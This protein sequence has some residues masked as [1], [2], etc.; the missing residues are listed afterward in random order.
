MSFWGLVM[1]P[2][3]ACVLAAASQGVPQLASQQPGGTS[4]PKEATQQ[5]DKVSG[6]ILVLKVDPKYTTRA[7]KAGIEGTVVL[8]I[9]VEPDGK[10][11]NIL[12]L[13]SLDSDLDQEAILAVSQWRFKP[14]MKDGKPVTVA[15]T[16]EVNFRLLQSDEY[17]AAASER[18]PKAGVKTPPR[19]SES[20]TT[21]A[22]LS[23]V[24]QPRLA[25]IIEPKYPA[26][27]LGS[28]LEGKVLIRIIVDTTGVP[29]SPEIVESSDPRLNEAAKTA[30]REWRY[31]PGKLNGE[32]T[33]LP[34]LAE[35]YFEKPKG[36]SS[37]PGSDRQTTARSS[38]EKT[39]AL[40]EHHKPTPQPPRE[41]KEVDFFGTAQTSLGNTSNRLRLR[42]ENFQLISDWR[43]QN[44]LSQLLLALE[45]ARALFLH[46]YGKVPEGVVTVIVNQNLEETRSSC[47]T[48][49]GAG[50]Y[51]NRAGAHSIILSKDAF[52]N[53]A[54][55]PA[56]HEYTHLAQ[57]LMGYDWA[58]PWV[59]EGIAGY[60]EN[61]E[62]KQGKL[63][64][65]YFDPRRPVPSWF[66]LETIM[67]IDY[68]TMKEHMNSQ[69]AQAFYAESHL[70]IHMLRHTPKYNE[71]LSEFLGA[72]KKGQDS[73]TAVREFYGVSTS[74]LNDELVEYYRRGKYKKMEVYEGVRVPNSITVDGSG[75]KV[76]V[77]EKKCTWCSVRKVLRHVPI[78]IPI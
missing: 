73:K 54:A 69:N 29:Q 20:K 4:P 23:G 22:P 14:G 16:V 6:P 32:P 10:P 31:L 58:P 47:Q 68:N 62:F 13:R 57:N 61:I 70:L 1:A 37:T 26:E 63:Y 48:T 51:S 65:G 44:Q 35:I 18:V 36:T 39:G 25:H 33:E 55:A 43:D 71:R 9:E 67:A 59:K 12:V 5:A 2:L 60:Y 77:K 56:V 41:E 27:L 3:L 28:G 75:Q 42:S 49:F 38:S 8:H 30:V 53:G 50:C 17:T 74:Q 64:V 40:G 19:P 52:T 66:H 21:R 45:R 72:V 24:E 11:Q 78:I 76:T 15:A 34:A 46:L 7:S